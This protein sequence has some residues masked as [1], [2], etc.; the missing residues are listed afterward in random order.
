ML[1]EK[2]LVE[3]DRVALVRSGPGLLHHSL[4]IPAPPSARHRVYYGRL[5]VTAP[6]VVSLSVCHGMCQE[7]KF[8]LYVGCGHDRYR[9]MT[10]VRT[11]VLACSLKEDCYL[12]MV[13]GL[14]S[15]HPDP[16]SLTM[17]STDKGAARLH[18]GKW[19]EQC[20]G[21]Y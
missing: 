10:T 4:A 14:S 20:A 2:F 16:L 15:G 1:F 11:R 13:E 7:I 6:S 12:V 3:F 19:L 8:C 9:L 18:P 17:Q 21:R 5:V